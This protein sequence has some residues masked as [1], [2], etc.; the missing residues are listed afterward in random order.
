[1]PVGEWRI[2]LS[3][4]LIAVGMVALILIA[5]AFFLV[6]HMFAGAGEEIGKRWVDRAA[7]HLAT[8]SRQRAASRAARFGDDP[9][10]V[11]GEAAGEPALSA[12]RDLARRQAPTPEV[13]LLLETIDRREPFGE[14]SALLVLVGPGAAEDV[15]LVLKQTGRAVVPA[16]KSVEVEAKPNT[17][18]DAIAMAF[19]DEL[20]RT[21]SSAVTEVGP[22]QFLAI[23]LRFPLTGSWEADGFLDRKSLVDEV[24]SLVTVDLW[25]TASEPPLEDAWPG[26]VVL[27]LPLDSEAFLESIKDPT[28]GTFSGATVDQNRLTV[29]ASD[30][31]QLMAILSRQRFPTDQLDGPH[32]PV[33]AL[34][35]LNF[36]TETSARTAVL[37]DTTEAEAFLTFLTKASIRLLGDTI[38]NEELL[39]PLAAY[40]TRTVAWLV[41]TAR[42]GPP[43]APVARGDSLRWL[44]EAVRARDEDV[45]TAILTSHGRAWLELEDPSNGIHVLTRAH[46]AFPRGGRAFLWSHYLLA[47]DQALRLEEPREAWF[48]PELCDL[49]WDTELGPLFLAERM[50]FTRLRGNLAGAVALANELAPLLPALPIATSAEQYVAGTSWY[51]LANVLRAGG[52]Y[53]L[54]RR[55][56]Q[57]AQLIL[58][59]NIESHNIELTHTLYGMNVCDSMFG[60]PSIMAVD[61]W[62]AA[63]AVFGRSLVILANSHAAWF[64]GDFTASAS[65]A[66]AAA[67]GFSSINYWRYARRAE[68][69]HDLIADW[70]ARNGESLPDHA[71]SPN[72][73]VD[74]LLSSPEGQTVSWLHGERP[75]RVLS[76]LQFCEAFGPADSEREVLLPSVIKGGLEGDL[77]LLDVPSGAT[78]ADAARGLRRAMGLADSAVT[79]LA[80]D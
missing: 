47:L 37:R 16:A 35:T 4:W 74:A 65:Y 64:I 46:Q 10:V 76:L 6:Q 32:Q 45:A 5:V 49:A 59:S 34:L 75:S 57:D 11:L 70:A 23:G 40:P 36:G 14:R 55:C 77:A 25:L 3:G 33:S 27:E 53:A 73:Q 21:V 78:Y 13:V 60:V 22:D 19:R 48:T 62:A 17:Q 38:E 8:R 2:C 68:A 28:R 7:A 30:A 18:A 43:A 71:G 72:P 9:R 42:F 61:S 41:H 69:L 79:P 58:N 31:S 12:L 66:S 56:I 26:T 39:V 50:E 29:S 54:A 63:E 44:D 20:L 15:R 80:A 1:L 52:N 67:T 51:V 24:L